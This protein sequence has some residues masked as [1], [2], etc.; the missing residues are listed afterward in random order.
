MTE[1]KL[2]VQI[3]KNG[4]LIDAGIITGTNSS[5]AFFS[6][7]DDYIKESANRAISLS[8][9]KE[10]KTFTSLQ[11]KNFFEGLLPEGFTRRQI[12]ES[13]HADTEDYISILRE[14]GNECLGAIRV[15]DFDSKENF[16]GYKKLSKEEVAALAQEGVRKSADIVVKSHLSLTGASGKVGLYYSE[17][18]NEWFQPFGNAPSTHIVKQSHV[19][20]DNIVSNEQLCLLTAKK[21]GI[22]VPDSFI[23]NTS[24]SSFSDESILFATKRY[25]RIVKEGCQEINGLKVPYRLH[26]EDFAQALGISS[27]DK[28]EK[29]G[30]NYLKKMFSLIRSN[31]SNPMEDSIKLWKITVFNYLIGNTD[32]HIKNLS[33]L[34]SEDLKSLSL[35]PAY[36]IVSTKI[37]KSSTDEMSL[38]INGKF[39]CST[40]TKKDFEAEAV[41]CGLGSKMAM[42]IYDQLEEKFQSALKESMLELKENGFADVETVFASVERIKKA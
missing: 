42:S 26:Q 35:A 11:T 34:Y 8:L 22:E 5:D 17:N 28:Y 39:E 30:G 2:R 20:L 36:D 1:I 37:Y 19:R 33:I 9:P 10:Q 27:Q 15:S 13:I 25:D 31:F 18:D 38:S 23:V 7:S 41:R 16:A 3:E 40:I 4:N 21:L 12:A 29:A 14:L 6:Y 32:N 24:D